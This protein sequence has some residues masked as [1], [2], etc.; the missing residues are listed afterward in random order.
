MYN[1][2]ALT[3]KPAVGL[4][5]ICALHCLLF[6]VAVVLLPSVGMLAFDDEAFHRGI[7]GAVLPAS[8]IALTMG[9]RKHKHYRLYLA[10]AVGL[11]LM[12]MATYPGHDTLGERGEKLMTL[13]GAVI[14]ALSHV[15]DFRLC[16]QLHCRHE[17]RTDR[18][19]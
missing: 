15:K 5:V 7:L 17:S 3:D 4:S 11:T 2:Q 8:L 9:C 16:R 10:G 19:L 12:G 13:V 14:I 1:W 6:P 18:G